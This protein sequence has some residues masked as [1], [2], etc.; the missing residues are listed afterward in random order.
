MLA[1]L[2]A[3]MDICLNA[4]KT[5][6][7]Y[8]GKRTSISY[9]IKLNDKPI[10]WAEEWKYLGVLVRSGPKYGCSVV[11]RVKSFYRSL[12]SILRVQGRIS[13]NLRESPG[14]QMIWY[15]YV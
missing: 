13:G 1:Q 10:L 5:R 8:F 11:E 3:V 7:L 15:C 12:N 14:D 4:K 2:L 6:N 9:E